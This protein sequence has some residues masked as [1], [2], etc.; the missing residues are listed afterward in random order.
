MIGDVMAF[1]GHMGIIDPSKQAGSSDP[2][3]GLGTISEANP[4]E[5]DDVGTADRNENGSGV[6]ASNPSMGKRE[7]TN[8]SVHYPTP[9]WHEPLIPV[10]NKTFR[11]ESGAPRREGFY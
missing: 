10:V 5:G 11:N 8:P 3:Q 1:A 7:L 9:D 6:G 2:R 4:V